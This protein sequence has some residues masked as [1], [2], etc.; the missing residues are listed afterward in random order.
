MKKIYSGPVFIILAAFLWS[1]DGFLRQS[2]Y[3]LPA[4]LIVWLEHLLGFIVVLPFIF[5]FK[6]DLKL[7]DRQTWFSIGWVVIWGGI[8]GTFFYT[9]ALGLVNY[10]DL[11][12]VVL[13]QK[14]QPVF[15]ITLALV[16]LREKPK[17]SYWFWSLL[18][19]VGGYL[20]TFKDLIINFHGG[21]N[22]IYAAGLALLAAFAWGSST[23]FGR[24]ALEIVNYKLLTALRFGLTA[25]VLLPIIFINQAVSSLPVVSSEQ[26]FKL[27]IIVFSTG[28][29]AVIIYYAGLRSTRASIATICEMFWPVSAVI[30]DYT[31]NK[32]ILTPTQIL[33]ALILLLAIYRL[34]ANQS[35]VKNKQIS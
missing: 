35:L 21:L 23:V 22:E 7:I 24:R 27:M 28:L 1:L 29:V 17:A 25:L 12:V 4:T 31:I 19:L 16:V 5:K 20:V 14:F 3:T 18:A 13:L 6:K 34:S 30:L 32:T 15:A 8:L 10:I 9:K 26:W 33:G 11:S 2:L